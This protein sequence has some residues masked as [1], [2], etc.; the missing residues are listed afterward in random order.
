MRHIG[1]LL[2]GWA[3]KSIASLIGPVGLGTA[4][5]LCTALVGATTTA[6]LPF[7]QPPA[8][9]SP[10]H[11]GQ[12]QCAATGFTPTGAINGVCQY[13]YGS[14]ARY[15]ALP[16]VL[17]R[18]QWSS[19]LSTASVVGNV[20]ATTDTFR[21]YVGDGCKVNFNPTGT[22][23]VINGVPYY[24]VSANGNELVNSNGQSYLVTP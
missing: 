1:S 3:M 21:R 9:D 17:Y 2:G 11:L 13:A 5:C 22:V 6:P 14:A 19:D 20:C 8:A 7:V 18:V 10:F 16:T 15:F 12:S 23:V 24:Y 4:F